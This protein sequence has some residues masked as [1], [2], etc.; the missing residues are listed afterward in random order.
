MKSTLKRQLAK[1]T[2][3]KVRL[4]KAK[5][6]TP[7]SRASLP[8]R[9]ERPE[10]VYNVGHIELLNDTD[11]DF[12]VGYKK[13]SDLQ[14]NEIDLAPESSVGLTL[15]DGLWNIVI[16]NRNGVIGDYEFDV[17]PN[18][19]EVTIT[20]SDSSGQMLFP[21]TQLYL[22]NPNFQNA[23]PK[24]GPGPANMP[25]GWV[26]LDNSDAITFQSVDDEGQLAGIMSVAGQ[27]SAEIGQTITI[28]AG[29]SY[30]FQVTTYCQ[31]PQGAIAVGTI[32]ITNTRN[33]DSQ[34]TQFHIDWSDHHWG[35][36]RTPSLSL[37]NASTEV[38]V[39]LN[40]LGGP[41]KDVGCNLEL[42]SALLIEDA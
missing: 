22:M 35:V 17:I 21:L 25:P 19:P 40:L 23:P 24:S 8:F 9:V 32:K 2:D 14:W 3:V 34:P 20:I 6:P 1:E 16:F 30:S 41:S 12:T 15:S 33:G 18:G 28:T 7:K 42:C 4:I 36:L 39:S 26:A 29:H 27:Q 11:T 31:Y 13:D 10:Q 38:Q 5:K 37:D